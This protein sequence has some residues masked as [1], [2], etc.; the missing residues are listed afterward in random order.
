MD[1][2]KL[3]PPTHTTRV[4]AYA[5][6]YRDEL[7]RYRSRGETVPEHLLANYN[8]NLLPGARLTAEGKLC[9]T[10]S[11]KA[12]HANA[13]CYTRFPPTYFT[14][15]EPADASNHHYSYPQQ[16]ATAKPWASFF[17]SVL[18]DEERERL[19]AC[20]KSNCEHATRTRK[21]LRAR[22]AQAK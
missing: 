2:N 13:G 21:Q 3:H 16:Q 4:E 1:S 14:P 18:L 10:V 11:L 20:R 9:Y 19:D 7:E 5:S 17:N 12:A 6:R 15:D 22:R 8:K